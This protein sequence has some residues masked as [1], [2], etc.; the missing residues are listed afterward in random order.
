MAIALVNHVSAKSSAGGSITSSAI[1]NTGATLL[2]AAMSYYVGSGGSSAIS[3]SSGNTWTPLTLRSDNTANLRLQC[4]YCANPTVSSSQTFTATSTGSSF[5]AI[6]V[7]SFS[8]VTTSTPFDQENGGG[9]AASTTHQPGSITP[10][11]SNELI[12]TGIECNGS[13]ANSIDSSYTITDSVAPVGGGNVG[14][15][16][17]Y[18]V[19]GAASASNPTWTM[20]ASDTAAL[21][22]A[23]FKATAAAVAA[24]G[25]NLMMLGV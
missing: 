20:S 4:Y 23:S 9:V 21:E 17:A 6:A 19:Q 13:T 25:S 1:N 16:L 11:Q 22:I 2:V 8:G 5:P 12:I 14:V 24:T 10:T 18:L 3:D 7:A 15:A